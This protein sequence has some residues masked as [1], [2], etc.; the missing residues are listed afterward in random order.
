[1]TASQAEIGVALV[2]EADT[3]AARLSLRSVSR[4]TVPPASIA[5]LLGDSPALRRSGGTLIALPAPVERIDV[6]AGFSI[7]NAALAAAGA[8]LP[9]DGV[10][11]L[12][13][14]GLVL[15]PQLFGEL[16][17]R[18]G[19]DPGL[20]AGLLSYGRGGLD[21]NELSED[22]LATE[23]PWGL[24]EATSGYER[25]AV[26][27]KARYLRPCLLAVRAGPAR[28]LGFEEFSS[29]G[30]WYAYKRLL[31][32]VDA[33]GR[34]FEE[35]SPRVGYVGNQPDRRDPFE[36]G[37]EAARALYRIAAGYPEFAGEVHADFTTLVRSQLRNLLDPARARTARGFLSG[38]LAQ[39]WAQ[40][41]LR[42][43]LD[44]DIAELS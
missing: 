22:R 8:R 35:A 27:L 41:A 11:V 42:R 17:A 26:V 36:Q 44:R 9:D 21:I 39:R 43:R 10:V 25:A 2:C 19:D 6:R 5:V 38:M 16:A 29:L 7:R 30:D 20:V 34:V 37:Q 14:E 24:V 40:R 18:F 4:Q 32:E 28:S 31:A 12:M 1:M 15:D 33:P 23:N 3:R 13:R